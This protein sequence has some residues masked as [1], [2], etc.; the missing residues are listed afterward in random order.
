[1]K[2]HSK[3]FGILP[4]A[5]YKKFLGE[6]KERVRSAQLK[7]AV[8]VNK[9]LI[10]LYWEIGNAVRQKQGKEGWGAKTI[11]KLAHDLKSAFSDMK[12]FSKT[13]LKYMVQFANEY[14]DFQI[15]QQL[16]GQIP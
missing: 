12:G 13:N 8:T 7:A 3:D 10:K 9:E 11:D 5:E 16:V 4:S 6:V 2:E 15:S 1:M 14:P